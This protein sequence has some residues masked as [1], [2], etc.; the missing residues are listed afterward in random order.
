M[1]KKRINNQGFTLLELLVSMGIFSLIMGAAVWLIVTGL[2]SNSIIWDQLETQNDGRAVLQNVVDDTRRAEYSSVGSY[3]IVLAEDYEFIF[4][5]NIDNDAER[6]RVRFRLDGSDVKRGIINPTGNP[7]TYDEDNEEEKIIGNY[8][9]NIA[10]G[11][12]LFFYYDQSYGGT[13][14]PLVTPATVT[15]VRAVRVNLEIEKDA[16]KTPVPLQVEST[17]QIRNLKTN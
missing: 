6:E 8:V 7:F 17:V 9:V 2:R 1:K 12:P 15:D 3:P 16:E 13:S 11:N 4:Y 14:T 5:A 10:E